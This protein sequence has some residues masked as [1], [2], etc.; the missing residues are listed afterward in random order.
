MY[1]VLKIK[2]Y[3]NFEVLGIDQEVPMKNEKIAGVCL[4]FN[5][6]DDALSYA[7]DKNLIHKVGK[8]N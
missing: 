7:E 4:V 1:L 3:M 8:V 6:Y 5:N 2:E